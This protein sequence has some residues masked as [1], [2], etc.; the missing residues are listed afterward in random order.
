MWCAV[1]MRMNGNRDKNQANGKYENKL[2]LKEVH[3]CLQCLKYLEEDGDESGLNLINC[4]YSKGGFKQHLSSTHNNHGRSTFED[5]EE[6]Y[7]FSSIVFICLTHI[8]IH[9]RRK[10]SLASRSPKDW[11]YNLV[12]AQEEILKE[13]T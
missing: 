13:S 2:Q 8:F 11:F 4:C 12:V 1:S 6:V 7:V 9:F 5:F 3:I 10:G